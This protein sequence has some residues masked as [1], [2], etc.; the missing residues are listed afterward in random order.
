MII[1]APIAGQMGCFKIIASHGTTSIPAQYVHKRAIRVLGWK[2]YSAKGGSETPRKYETFSERAKST[3]H[4]FCIPA[5][6]ATLTTVTVLVL[7][8]STL[9]NQSLCSKQALTISILLL[10]KART[11]PAHVASGDT[12]C[13]FMLLTASRKAQT[14][15]LVIKREAALQLAVNT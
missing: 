10:T 7:R 13:L 1:I 6:M 12:G 9:K 11:N 3:T 2:Y 14:V 4:Q 8:L 15:T 5:F